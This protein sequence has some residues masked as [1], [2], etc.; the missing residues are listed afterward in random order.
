MLRRIFTVA[1]VALAMGCIGVPAST[2]AAQTEQLLEEAAKHNKPMDEA[3][4]AALN[5]MLKQAYEDVKQHYYEP[6]FRGLDWDGLYRQYQ[7]RMAKLNNTGEGFRLIAAFLGELKDSHTF[8]SPPTRARHFDLGF[9]MQLEGNRTFI[10]RVRPGSDA[11]KKLHPGDEVIGFNGFA[12]NRTDTRDLTY[13]FQTL[14]P[15]A[16]TELDLL[17]LDGKRRKETVNTAVHYLAQTKEIDYWVY[18]NDM[19]LHLEDEWRR[20]KPKTETIGDVVVWKIHA[21]GMDYEDVDRAIGKARGHKALVIDLRDNPGGAIETLKLVTGALFER[22]VTIADQVRRKNT[23]PIVA[24]HNWHP[25]EG[26]VI[27]LVNADSASCSELLARV[28]QLEHRGTVVGDRSAGAVMESIVHVE[29]N[30]VTVPYAFSITEADLLMDD[31][32]SLENVGVQP[33]EQVLLTAAD[34]AA[35]RDPVLARA[36]ELAGGKITPEE[37][38]KLFPYKWPML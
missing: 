6:S 20:E 13:Y 1:T 35:G 10:T 33:D 12:V 3:G 16:A 31:R 23:K 24:K 37:A 36:V 27:V 2:A 17:G 4:R 5:A 30:S 7:A 38:G 29:S 28:V 32:K 8:F 21:F 11:E 22:D 15:R 19:S 34:L 14:S 25:F 26:K 9:R 18:L